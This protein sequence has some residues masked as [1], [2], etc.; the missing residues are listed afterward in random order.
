MLHLKSLNCVYLS[1][2]YMALL[3]A[4]KVF[5]HINHDKLFAKLSKRGAPQCFIK[6]LFSW[7]S[8]LISCVCWNG[9]FSLEF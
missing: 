8:K 6:V 7:Y 4:S 5:D 2:V 9:V 3:D 1:P